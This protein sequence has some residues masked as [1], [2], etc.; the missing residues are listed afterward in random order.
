MKMFCSSLILEYRLFMPVGW[1][2][3]VG[4]LEFAGIVMLKNVN[5]I[6]NVDI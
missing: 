3:K 5:K 2:S 4:K 6:K 1:I